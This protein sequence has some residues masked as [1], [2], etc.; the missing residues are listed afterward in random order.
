MNR[1]L[2]AVVIN[3]RNLLLVGAAVCLG[4]AVWTQPQT[5]IGPC[6]VKSFFIVAGGT[7]DT[8]MTVTGSGKP[9]AFTLIYSAFNRFQTA[10]LITNLPAHGRAE[11]YLIEGGTSALVSYTPA[12]GYSGPDKFTATIEPGNKAVIVTVAVRAPGAKPS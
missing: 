4:G 11:A 5:V 8:K 7:S 10:A 12:P 1:R 2:S 9:C 3:G 6:K